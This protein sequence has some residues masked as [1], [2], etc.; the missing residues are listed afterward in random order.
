M[1][2]KNVK[3]DKKYK[4]GQYTPIN[5]HKY[6]G[7]RPIIYRS[8]WE[9]KY[10]MYCDDNQDIISWSSEPFV[11]EYFNKLTGKFH[12]YY[13]DFYIKVRNSKGEFKE[14]IVEIKPK[15]SIKKPI[16]PKRKTI[17]SVK[18]YKYAVETYIKNLSKAKA[19]KIFAAARG[20]KF[21]ILTE[22]SLR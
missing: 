6:I 13:P 14:Y 3:P 9:R 12:K 10:C 15:S 7:P 21:I 11:I 20:M 19:A 8:G 16:E 1:S 2:I 22:D 5:E 17:Q 4:G 18:N